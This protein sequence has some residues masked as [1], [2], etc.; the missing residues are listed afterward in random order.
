MSREEPSGSLPQSPKRLW[1]RGVTGK[2]KDAKMKKKKIII[3]VSI[4]VG[5]ILFNV[6]CFFGYKALANH[7]KEVYKNGIQNNVKEFIL[8]DEYF[9]S[10][11]G[12]PVSVEF[13]DDAK[14]EELK[15][16]FKIIV[17]SVV[18]TGGNV[19]Y[20]VTVNVTSDGNSFQYEYASVNSAQ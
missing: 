15:G 17:G 20:D 9:K 2:R 5:V 14:Y 16:T 3:I 7:Q 18:E 10:T 4:I 6:V 13:P 12:D 19:K 1:G 11:Y 8:N